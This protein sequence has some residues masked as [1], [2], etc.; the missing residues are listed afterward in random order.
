MNSRGWRFP[1]AA[2]SLKTHLAHV[3]LR[4]GSVSCHPPDCR[5]SPRLRLFAHLVER[6]KGLSRNGLP[7]QAERDTVLPDDLPVERAGHAGQVKSKILHDVCSL[8]F[9]WRRPRGPSPKSWSSR[10]PSFADCCKTIIA[11]CL[12]FGMESLR[13]LF[14]RLTG[15]GLGLDRDLNASISIG[16]AGSALETLNAHGGDGRWTGSDRAT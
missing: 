12:T 2:F 16:V 8:F 1:A 14:S 11:Q 10:P 9:S 5:L 4:G 13:I 3:P 7:R 15:C 6:I